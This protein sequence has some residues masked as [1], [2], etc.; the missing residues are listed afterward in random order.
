ML[1]PAIART[2]SVMSFFPTDLPF[3]GPLPYHFASRL[4]QAQ[5]QK[6]TQ[7]AL[8]ERFPTLTEEHWNRIFAERRPLLWVDEQAQTVVV[9][10]EALLRL[11][12]WAVMY[13]ATLNNEP[14]QSE[15][16]GHY[17]A[18]QLAYYCNLASELVAVDPTLTHPSSI[19][20]MRTVFQRLCV[21][22]EVAERLS[23]PLARVM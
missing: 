2:N 12:S 6:H 23:E 10:K 13:E 15:F 7:S 17:L 5:A 21:G 1:L 9:A 8:W 16:E 4:Y 20:A 3:T 11:V 14:T 18:K 22:N 19:T